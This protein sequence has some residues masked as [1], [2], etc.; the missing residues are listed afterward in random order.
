MESPQK[1]EAF[2]EELGCIK[3]NKIKE[4][5]EEAVKILPDY[6]FTMP[7]STTG[8]YH[9]DY[10][11]GEGGLLRHTR[12]A[13]RFL[14]EL[15]RN[16]IFSFTDEEFDLGIVALILHDGWKLGEAKTSYSVANHPE[17]AKNVLETSIELVGI[18]TD[19]QFKIMTDLIWTHMGQWNMDWK[20]KKEILP[21]PA[22]PLQE[23][24][25]LC[26]YLASRKCIVMDFDKP[27]ST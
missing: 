1:I 19:E 8:K 9:P 16:K 13:I 27:L 14:M 22:T 3:D 6:F 21:I 24:V 10:T 5:A 15:S 18:I 23:L 26:D 2:K 4:F 11:L 25:H 12:S 17:F 7:A 20:S